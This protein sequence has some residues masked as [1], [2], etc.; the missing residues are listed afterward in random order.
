MAVTRFV[1]WRKGV[2]ISEEPQLGLVRVNLNK[3]L[4]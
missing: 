1:S 3:R 2:T 4:S